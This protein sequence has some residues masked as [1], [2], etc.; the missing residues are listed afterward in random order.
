[1]NGMRVEVVS[2]DG[3]STPLEEGLAHHLTADA[4]TI[5]VGLKRD[6]PFVTVTVDFEN[7]GSV[8]ERRDADA[9]DAGEDAGGSDLSAGRS[10]PMQPMLARMR[11]VRTCRPVGLC[12]PKSEVIRLGLFGWDY[13]AGVIRPEPAAAAR[14]PVTPR[15]VPVCG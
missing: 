10:V 4:R 5:V 8:V 9:T 1:D 11:V 3:Q 13:S 15:A 14:A 7:R 12:R 6:E 2:D